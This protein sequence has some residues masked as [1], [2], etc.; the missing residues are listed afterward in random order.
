MNNACGVYIYGGKVG[1]VN[2]IAMLSLVIQIGKEMFNN[3]LRTK[4]AFGYVVQNLGIGI[5]DDKYGV[6]I[7]QSEKENDEIEKRIHLFIA[8]LQTLIDNMD[9]DEIKIHKESVIGDY[10]ED[11][12]NLSE[13]NSFYR[14]LY[15]SDSFDMD[16]KQ[17]IIEA[18]RN[19]D[20]NEILISSF[21]SAVVYA[22]KK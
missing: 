10:K 5:Y 20:K 17:K 22:D 16:Y 4:E 18:V 14:Y 19:V 8:E 13:F 9:D 7:V 3:Q 12:K 21:Y 11:F 15:F 1:D 2:S 6:Y